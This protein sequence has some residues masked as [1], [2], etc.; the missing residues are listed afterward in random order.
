[1]TELHQLAALVDAQQSTDALK[2]VTVLVSHIKPTL[3]RSPDART[4]IMEQVH[5]LNDAGIRFLFPEQGDR[6]AL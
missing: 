6:L 3:Q 2:G 1:M 5:E 4:Q